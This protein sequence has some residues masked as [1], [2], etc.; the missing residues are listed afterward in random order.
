M[1]SSLYKL[2]VYTLSCPCAQW[3]RCAPPD[4]LHQKF[5]Q[6]CNNCLPVTNEV[7]VLPRSSSQNL[8]VNRLSSFVP[9]CNCMD[10]DTKYKHSAKGMSQTHNTIF[11]GHDKPALEG[12]ID[13]V[14]NRGFGMWDGAMTTINGAWEPGKSRAICI[15]RQTAGAPWWDSQWAARVWG[16]SCSFRA[17]SSTRAVGCSSIDMSARQ[18]PR[19]WNLPLM[20]WLVR[21]SYN[22]NISQLHHMW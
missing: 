16:N 4:H 22:Y 15:P 21:D 12:S 5:I 13:R 9:K 11:W 8:W 6:D 10:Y 18:C 7:N 19:K 14:E 3:W 20:I 17:E 1:S 2:I